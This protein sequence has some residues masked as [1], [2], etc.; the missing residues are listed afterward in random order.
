MPSCA[1][2]WMAGWMISRITRAW[3]FGVT[4]GAGEYAPM[5]PVLGPSSP[6][7]R[8]LWS[9]LVA[10]GSA[11]VPSLMT[12]KLASSPCRN[13][14]TTTRAP[15]SP[16]LFCVIMR[17]MAACASSTL[18]ATTTPF[19][20][21]SPSALITIG[22]P[23]LATKALARSALWNVRC[24]AVGMLWRTMNALAKSLE[25]SS[26]TAAR[27][28]PKI[29]IPAS[30]KAST[31]P[32][33]SAASG[34]TTVSWMPS[35]FANATSS[36]TSES[37]TFSRPFS[38]AVP[39]LPGAT[40]TFCTFGLCVSFHA[41]A[42]SRPPDPIT[43]SFMSVA[44]VPHPGE[45]HGDAALVRGRDHFRVAHAAPGLDHRGGAGVGKRVEPVA[46]REESVRR[47]DRGLEREAGARRLHGGD[48]HAVDAAHLSRAHAERHALAAEYDCVRLHVLGDAPSE[49]EVGALRL[50]RRHARDEP[51]ILD[52][53]RSR[54]AR[55]HQQ[56]AA[57]ALV[58]VRLR[59]VGQR[60]LQ[61]PEVSFPGKD[62]LCFRLDARRDHH[63]GEL[64]GERFGGLRVERAVER[65]DPAESRHR[66]GL[67]RL[68]V[69]FREGVGDGGA[70]GV[71][72]LDD[73]A[74]RVG[75]A[76][77]ALPCRV[78]VGD[79]VV[80]QF[81]SLDLAVGGD[82]ARRAAFVTVKSRSLVGVLAV[83]EVFD[84]LEL[85]VEHL[86]IFLP[87]APGVERRKIVGDRAVVRRRMREHFRRQ[88]E[89]RRGRHLAAG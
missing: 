67:E 3:I 74:G 9:W 30:R 89:A 58:V 2:P 41:M 44:E 22:A 80:G 81:L 69:G 55:L 25:D 79:V 73:H 12:M 24:S 8:R 52:G 29:L 49:H 84:L 14:S 83:A 4:I 68:R 46:E 1:M 56:T 64:G 85:Q 75:E 35:F 36:A 10:S 40:K 61:H 17:S 51:E 16:R 6:S 72:V 86:R 87:G 26:C 60:H 76:L 47:H 37:A 77:D 45:D 78:R 71:G 43:R 65:Q 28:A 39:P 7:R 32:A 21:A 15:A 62:L 13:S 70:A 66:I 82:P 57:D 18:A 38:R 34:P 88:L 31:T 50:A 48:A 23:R 11:L 42:C 20:A 54:V 33:A 5:P 27:V 53:E 59:A 63:L 19:P